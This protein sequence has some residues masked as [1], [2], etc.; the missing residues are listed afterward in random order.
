MA[1]SFIELNNVGFWA[2][3][4]FIEAIQYCIIH[5]IELQNFPKDSWVYEYRNQIALQS[6]PLVYGGMSMCLE[7]IVEKPIII[8]IIDQIVYKINNDDDYF[9]LSNM[10]QMQRRTMKLLLKKYNI[11]RNDEEIEEDIRNG[12]WSC[13]VCIS[14]LKKRYICAFELLNTLI[15]GELNESCDLSTYLINLED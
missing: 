12:R 3:D 2:S 14:K 8:R 10:Q 9:T 15:K 6:I 11:Y 7:D 5:E 13:G 4:G 1:S